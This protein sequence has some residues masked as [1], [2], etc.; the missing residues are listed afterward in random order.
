[1][2]GPRREGGIVNWKMNLAA[3]WLSQFLSLSAFSFCFPFFPLY[4]KESG[5]VPADEVQSWSGIFISC[6]SISMMI[7]S[8]IWGALGDRYGRKMMLVRA[9]LAGAFVLYLMGVVTKIEALI[10]LRLL[11]GAFTGTVTAA[12][13]LIVTNTPDKNQGFA[14]GVVM[15]AVNA[16]QMAGLYFGGISAKHFGVAASFKI[17][18]VMLMLATILVVAV[19]RE[20]FTR[21]VLPFLNSQSARLRRRRESV[22]SFVSG[23][24]VLA[25]IGAV[26]FIQSVDGPFLALYIDDLFRAGPAAAVMTDDAVVGR[27]YGLTANVSLLTSIAAMLGSILTGLFMDKKMSGGILALAALA[28]GG[29]MFLAAWFPSLTALVVGRGLFLFFISG[30]ASVLVVILGRLTPPAKRGGALG[31]AVTSRSIGW[32]MA[33]LWGAFTAKQYGWAAS[34]EIIAF[35]GLMLAPMFLYLSR[36]YD[37]V[38]R[39]AEEDAPSPDAAG[40]GGAPSHSERS[41]TE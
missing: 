2:L 20:N 16:G 10:V 33:P 3:L 37:A 28:G 9:N 32:A 19:V 18:G 23:I 24:P 36:R 15:A 22:T 40:Q 25:V 14:I 7:M 8:P 35:L 17:A 11:Q 4:L 31:W 12:Q 39:P 1:M 21:P 13:T 34:F 38:F 27:V 41:A 29:A 30:L 5:I 6:S 26:A